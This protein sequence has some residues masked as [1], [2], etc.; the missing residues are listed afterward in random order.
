MKLGRCALSVILVMACAQ[1]RL[2]GTLGQAA[3]MTFCGL[4]CPVA[5]FCTTVFL[6]GSLDTARPLLAIIRPTL[7]TAVSEPRSPAQDNEIKKQLLAGCLVTVLAATVTFYA[8]RCA[9]NNACALYYGTDENKAPVTPEKPSSLT[10]VSP[11]MSQNKTQNPP[12]VGQQTGVPVVYQI[13][14]ARSFE[15]RPCAKK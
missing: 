4:L 10:P 1:L 13:V 15:Q 3:A 5:A 8:G 12:H 6:A 7:P 11:K 2:E 14:Q 9:W